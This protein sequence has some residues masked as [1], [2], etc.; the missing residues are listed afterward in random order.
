MRRALA[1]LLVATLSSQAASVLTANY[2]NTRGG[3]NAAEAT[4]TPTNVQSLIKQGT[5]TLDGAVLSQPLYIA[6]LT[7]GT[8]TYNALIVCTMKNT[9]YALDADRPGSAPLWSTN[10]GATW[11]VGSGAFFNIFY[12]LTGV[13]ILSTPVSD[14]TSLYVVTANN[15]PAYTLRKL[16]LAT[17]AQSASVNITGSVAGSGAGTVGGVTDDTTGSNLNFHPAWQLQRGALTFAN[18]NVYIAF[19]AAGTEDTVWHGWIFGYS[20]SAL[21]QV[22]VFCS[23]PNANGAGMW[24][25]GGAAA[26]ASGNLYVSSG[27][28]SWDGATAFAQT[29]FKL[30]PTLA[31]LDWFTPA[32]HTST[33]TIPPDAD[34]S[35]GRV[36]L[37][38][39][40]SF[41]TLGSKDGR[42]WLIDTMNMGHLQ[43]TGTAPQVITTTSFAAG[44]ETGTFGGLFFGQAGYFPIRGGA[45]YGYSFGG[46]TF[47]TTPL[48]TST[49]AY[50]QMT[51]AGSSNGGAN[52]IMW[53]LTADSD[54]EQTPRAA[55]VRALN[56]LTLV[57]YW[58]S[59]AGNI[60]TYSK[61]VSPLVANG[62]VY[63]PTWDGTVQAFGLIAQGTFTGQLTGA[64]ICTSGCPA[65]PQGIPGTVGQAGPVGATGPAGMSITG[66]IGPTGPAG[67][68]ITGPAGGTGPVGPQGPQG[69]AGTG[70]GGSANFADDE[71]PAGA[72]DGSNAVFTLV[73]TPITGA[74]L[75]LFIN[76]VL[77]LQGTDYAL[78]GLTVTFSS[79]PSA[80]ALLNAFYRY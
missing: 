78:S 48:A 9:V 8:A 12:S 54:P 33:Q 72:V 50:N 39:G 70:S 74:A 10:F 80:G 60:G 7:I 44:G 28:G 75:Q 45:M 43:G 17:G 20:T 58:N 32:N 35:S 26:D 47:A 42:V 30:S 66:P 5:Y 18:G 38:P 3:S 59:G 52:A 27:N 41:L 13:G 77:A 65:G 76:G 29:V 1:L 61:F 6:N 34:L 36:M 16:A 49:T 71:T 69:P 46:S 15:T 31:L 62:K 55:T 21:A 19:G 37:V 25:A 40:T 56:P 73:N 64:F 67:M 79:A 22:G 14:G 68:S 63:V 51:L 23:T 4:L 11:N 2:D 53:A 57:E 24:E